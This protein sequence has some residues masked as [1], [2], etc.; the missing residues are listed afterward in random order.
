MSQAFPSASPRSESGAMSKGYTSSVDSGT[1]AQHFA[2]GP[3]ERAR[4]RAGQASDDAARKRHEGAI[5]IARPLTAGKLRTLK[6]PN[7]PEGA[8]VQLTRMRMQFF[9][10]LL[11]ACGAALTVSAGAQLG[12]ADY[13]ALVGA[14]RMQETE[15]AVELRPFDP[16]LSMPEGGL[17]TL[18][19]SD[20]GTG[21]QPAIPLWQL[22]AQSEQPAATGGEDRA[23][24]HAL[25]DLEQ[26]VDPIYFVMAHVTADSVIEEAEDATSD[27]NTVK[28]ARGE[29]L[30]QLLLDARL[31]AGQAQ[32]AMD[33]LRPVFNPRSLRA[34]QQVDLAIDRSGSDRQ[35]TELSF[36]PD[37]LS[38]VKVTWSP[39]RGFSAEQ[40]QKPLTTKEVA[41]SGIVQ[42]SLF[43][44]GNRAGVPSSVMAK[45]LRTYSFNVDFQRDLK[46]G[47]TFE[48]LFERLYTEN[49]A[50]ARDGEILFAALT[51]AGKRMTIYRW[52]DED[53][54][55]DYFDRDGNSIR[56][57]LLRTPVDSARITSSYGMRRH[58]ILGFSKMHTGVDFAA[59]TGTPIYAAGDGTIKRA[60]RFSGY[61]NYVEI[62]H[63]G[64]LSTAYG[65]LSRFARNITAGAKV[66][67]GDVIGYSGA[68]GRATGPH[69]H[70]EVI[71]N[72]T[73]VNPLAVDMP[74]SNSL[75]G[76]QLKAF[77]AQAAEI[78]ARFAVEAKTPVAS[79]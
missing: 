44:A 3:E 71:R 14:S 24:T 45:M 9:K 64:Q 38:E 49:G 77:K 15:L 47:D 60:S 33:A 66:R 62:A 8:K 6:S 30:M 39:E 63:N 20:G 52:T 56:K 61:G 13:P 75:T 76:K 18:A 58:P 70:F 34:G 10:P 22:M 69:L 12:A 57:A 31:D 48:I 43:E 32:Q 37:G 5:G 16:G 51:V 59:P 42:S 17:E 41:A 72:G 4:R 29:T 11:A 26:E 7:A 2:P 1:R 67:Q 78:D 46:T 19:F 73:K 28:L 55:A 79:R 25:R 27:R 50:V 53:G 65:H 54:R 68:T 36:Q 35:L 74:A 21:S 23:A 40:T